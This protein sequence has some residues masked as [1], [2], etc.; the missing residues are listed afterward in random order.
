M[1]FP[2]ETWDLIKEYQLFYCPVCDRECLED[3]FRCWMDDLSQ[4]HG[5]QMSTKVWYKLWH[6]I[7]LARKRKD[8]NEI[9]KY[10]VEFRKRMEGTIA[11]FL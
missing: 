8:E 2:L 11:E 9:E 3:G 4:W 10:N 7:N 1:L 6:R 5:Q